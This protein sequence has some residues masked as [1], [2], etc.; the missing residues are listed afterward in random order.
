MTPLSLAETRDRYLQ[1]QGSPYLQHRTLT[2]IRG[3]ELFRILRDAI[4]LRKVQA[5]CCTRV[6]VVKAPADE[7]QEW[8]LPWATTALARLYP[9]LMLRRTHKRPG[10]QALE[11][12]HGL[13]CM[14]IE[15]LTCGVKTTR[16]AGLRGKTYFDSR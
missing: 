14:R 6:A 3:Q 12:T 4:I 15:I 13:I 10:I 2:A 7:H 1:V 11:G 16:I 5:L 8:L 9:T